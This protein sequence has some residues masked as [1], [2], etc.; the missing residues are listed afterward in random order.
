MINPSSPEVP[1]EPARGP[2]R[3]RCGETCSAIRDAAL[4]ILAE[5]GFVA[6]TIEEVA[7]RAGASKATVYRWWPGKAALIV[8]AFFAKVIPALSFPDTGSIRTDVLQQMRQVVEQ[9]NGPSGK[10]LAALVA[11]AQMDEAL[12]EGFRTRILTLR[13]AEGM[14]AVRRGIE[15]G[16]LPA[17]IDGEFF[18]DM[19]YS[20]LY[21]RL[22]VRHQPLNAAL[23]E[24]VVDLVLRGLQPRESTE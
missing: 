20:P 22:L 15:R 13:R 23:V 10:A 19:L 2:G 3:P 7:S 5:R 6:L 11:G 24:Q 1:A 18:F 17:D 9:M 16:E 4:E 12:A 14:K 21:F 8:D